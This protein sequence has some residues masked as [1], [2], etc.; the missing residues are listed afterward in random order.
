M[1]SK[2]QNIQTAKDLV[3]EVMAHG[4]ST[5]GD[6]LGR[7]QDILGHATFQELDFLANDLGRVNEKG[8]PDP[9]G[10]W[11]SSRRGTRDTFYFILFHVWNWEDATRFW[12]QHTN[13]DF[14]K[15]VALKKEVDKLI[16]EKEE[17]SSKLRVEIGE[18]QGTKRLLEEYTTVNERLHRENNVLNQQI[19]ELKAELY[20][21]MKEKNREEDWEE[22]I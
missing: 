21:L 18:H 4:L 6:N 1:A 22:T 15:T 20:D 13:P 5:E 12:N 3:Y 9:K 11:S 7:I 17:L 8:E 14:E 16:A 19:I 2:Y 10:T